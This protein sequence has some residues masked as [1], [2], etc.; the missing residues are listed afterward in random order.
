MTVDEAAKIIG[1]GKR[2]LQRRYGD[3]PF[4]RSIA[5]RTVRVSAPARRRWMERQGRRRTVRLSDTSLAQTRGI[6]AVSA[7]TR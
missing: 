1:V 6:Y 7:G 2:W 4:V 3:L 5:A